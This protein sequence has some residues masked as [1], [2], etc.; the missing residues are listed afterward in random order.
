MENPAL[1]YRSKNLSHTGVDGCS[2]ETGLEGS[3]DGR[4]AFHLRFCQHLWVTRPA[5]GQYKPDYNEAG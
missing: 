1:L 2:P 3:E 4:N 5:T